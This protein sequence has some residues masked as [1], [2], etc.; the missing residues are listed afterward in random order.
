MKCSSFIFGSGRFRETH[1]T[2]RFSII[3]GTDMSALC[4]AFACVQRFFAYGANG[5]GVLHDGENSIRI[6]QGPASNQPGPDTQE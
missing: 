6:T 5:I 1:G 3:E 2:I 4:A